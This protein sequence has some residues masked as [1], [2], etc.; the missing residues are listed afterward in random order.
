MSSVVIID[1]GTSN[2]FSIQNALNSVG[3]KTK[4]TSSKMDIEKA[5]FLILP[6]VGSFS[7]AMVNLNKKKIVH[8]ILRHIKEK[9]PFLGICLGFQLLFEYSYE[10]KKTKG[11]SL[12]KGDVREFSNDKVNT[13][14]HVG[15]N[16]TKVLNNKYNFIKN[17]DFYY[18]VHSFYVLPKNKKI[19]YTT[20]KVDNFSFCSSIIKNNIF[21]CQFHPEKSGKQGL[22]FL[23]NFLKFKHA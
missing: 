17:Q 23:K 21:G 20:T 1:S 12:L 22:K 16:S 2:L 18:F 8:P 19:I 11:L 3:A 6:G 10:F 5:D 9:K 15:W 7:Q 14:P 4:I 13:V